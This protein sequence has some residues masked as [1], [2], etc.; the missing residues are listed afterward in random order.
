MA[1]H[2]GHPRRNYLLVSITDHPVAHGSML[3]AKHRHLLIA[4]PLGQRRYRLLDQRDI[5]RRP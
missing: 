2:G 4:G 1:Q 3:E 5:G